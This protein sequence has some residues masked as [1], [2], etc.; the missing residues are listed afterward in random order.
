MMIVILSYDRN[1]IAGSASHSAAV[2]KGMSY[3]LQQGP[4][5]GDATA[6][7][8]S[9][10]AALQAGRHRRRGRGHR[11]VRRRPD[12]RRLLCPLLLEGGSGG[13][14]PRRPAARTAPRL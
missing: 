3:A 2:R 10:R 6:Y 9:R 5:A 8:R 12:E 7:P 13:E 11:D 1:I 14:R 4:E